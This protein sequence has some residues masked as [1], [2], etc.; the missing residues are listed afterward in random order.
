ME[1]PR[2]TSPGSIM[3]TYTWLFKQDTDY[4][5]LPG[6]IAVLRSLGVPF[7]PAEPEA[8]IAEAKAQAELIVNDLKQNGVQ[9]VPEKEI[10]ALTAYLQK[11]GQY[12][13]VAAPVVTQP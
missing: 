7:P 10:I 13:K 5:V 2:S 8:I 12:E 11:L 4:R 6:R 1:N 9:A 3:P